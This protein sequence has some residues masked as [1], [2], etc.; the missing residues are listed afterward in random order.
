MYFWPL[1]KNL[2]DAL[3]KSQSIVNYDTSGLN[4]QVP[5]GVKLSA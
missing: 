4:K 1:S 2:D 5:H 3:L